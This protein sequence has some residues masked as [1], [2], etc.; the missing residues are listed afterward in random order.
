MKVSYNWLKQY[1]TLN[2]TPEEIANKLTFSGIEVEEIIPFAQGNH[3]VIGHVLTCD[4]H[5]NSD[6]LHV[7]TVDEGEKHG[8]HTIVCGAPNVAKGQKVIVA[9]EGAELKGGTIIKS[10][11]R[12]IESDGMCC[13]LLEL[14]VDEKYLSD[15]QKQGIEVLPEDAPV[16]EEK[17]LEY[18][19]IDDVILDLKLLANRSDCLALV[20][21]IREIAA[22][23]DVP[24][25]LPTVKE[26]PSQEIPFT[27]GTKTAKCAQFA[28][29]PVQGI[30][31]GPSPKWMKSALNAMGIRSVNNIVDIGNYVML[32]YGQPLHMYD[33]DKLPAH[34]LVV[35]DDMEGDFVALDENT[36]RLEKG[37]LCVTSNGKV[38]CLG[39]VMGSLACAVDDTTKN[40]VVEAASFDSAT[41]RHTSSRLG[42]ISESSQR[43]VKG[44]QK[45]IE[46]K[47]L[48]KTAEL[49]QELCHAKVVGKIIDK[50]DRVIEP[51]KISSTYTKINGRLGTSLTKEEIRHALVR[52][53][54]DFEKEEGDAFVVRVPSHREDIRLSADLS[55][56]VIRLLGFEHVESTLPELKTTLGGLSPRQQKRRDIRE[57]LISNGLYEAV[58]YTLV[59]EKKN[60]MMENFH[61]HEVYRLL[62]PMTPD[63]Q[64][65][66]RNIL[67]SLLETA[68]YNVARK[69]IDFG[70]FELSDVYTKET[71][72]THLS[73]VLVGEDHYR[74]LMEKKPFGYA[75]VKG[76]LEGIMGLLAIEPTRY[77]LERVS[78]SQ[79]EFHPGRSAEIYLGK[80]LVGYLGEIHPTFAKVFDLQ[81]TPVAMMEL[82]LSALLELRVSP[83][84]TEAPSRFQVVERDLALVCKKSVTA[85]EITKVI[86]SVGRGFVKSV[87]IFD[88]YEGEHVL[89]GYQSI[90]LKIIYENKEKSFTSEEISSTE[91]AII[92]ALENKLQC[93]L[94]SGV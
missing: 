23:W 22:E 72:E 41:I 75:H 40:I 93:V 37:D 91:K 31:V 86:K 4:P 21:I 78:P 81:R 32:L 17:V 25:T 76:I 69:N 59:D 49:L 3:L 35:R 19:G 67:P 90:A 15:A 11:I 39:G 83:I 18:L 38:M 46:E 26:I 79:E 47:V 43:F 30:E 65:V 58:T 33:V 56:E 5:P 73:V 57:F 88:V 87:D 14:A 24:Y 7:L 6:H 94:R 52:I 64:I 63:H 84:K 1:L 82:N 61:Q 34:E 10:M 53:G 74:H 42:L 16:G 12:G 54:C 71:E 92:D 62:H 70:M 66:R 2:Q 29:M 44:I 50:D 13:S 20:N 9:M 28:A 36:Y 68:Q 45:G 85:Q 55:E 77:R 48:Q 8:V 51:T 27:V 89:E 80:T 60:A